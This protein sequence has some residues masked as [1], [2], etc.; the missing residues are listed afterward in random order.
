MNNIEILTVNQGQAALV[1]VVSRD[2]F[3]IISFLNWAHLLLK[4]ATRAK[5]HNHIAIIFLLISFKIL[6]DMRVV[7]FSHDG[8]LSKYCSLL[9]SYLIL[10]C[11]FYLDLFDG[12]ELI[13]LRHFR[14]FPNFSKTSLPERPWCID[15]I[16]HKHFLPTCFRLDVKLSW[17]IDTMRT[18]C[19]CA[20]ESHLYMTHN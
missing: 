12:I 16:Q 10:V 15:F 20:A 19:F 2:C 8:H 9:L 7:T 14:G 3:H 1:H 18:L 5:L 11:S 13:V 4:T 6:D 17:I